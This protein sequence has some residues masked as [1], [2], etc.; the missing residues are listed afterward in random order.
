MELKQEVVDKVHAVQTALVNPVAF[1]DPFLFEKTAEALNGL[2]P[3]F[4]Q[5]PVMLAPA[6]LALAVTVLAKLRPDEEWGVA[7]KRYCREMLREQGMMDFP[8]SMAM[9]KFDDPSGPMKIELDAEQKKIQATSMADIEDY[10][11]GAAV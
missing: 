1:G 8:P 10:V 2:S 9:L 5:F 11:A 6:R 7:V 4:D 3:D